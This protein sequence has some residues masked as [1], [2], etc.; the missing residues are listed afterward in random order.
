MGLDIVNNKLQN[1]GSKAELKKT[2]IK[3][4]AS[5][6]NHPPGL[7]DL[8]LIAQF[9]CSTKSFKRKEKLLFPHYAHK[10][11]L[12]NGEEISLICSAAIWR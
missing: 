1:K 2:G 3:I 10:Q 12:A 4:S 7:F 11:E 5:D 9:S 8:N 6:F